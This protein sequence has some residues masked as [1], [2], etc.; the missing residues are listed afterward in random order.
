MDVNV[1]STLIGLRFYIITL[2]CDQ[3]PF[4]DLYFASNR[5]STYSGFICSH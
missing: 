1:C 4:F 5:T 3:A 2:R